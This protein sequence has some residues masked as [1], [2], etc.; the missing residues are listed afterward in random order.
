MERQIEELKAEVRR[1]LVVDDAATDKPS[2]KLNM[3]NGIQ[4]LGVA[5]HFETEVA[6]ALEHIFLT[7]DHIYNENNDDDALYN[8]A[9]RFKLLRQ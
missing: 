1:K 8:V 4:R 5:Y 7:Y 2:Q 3:I 6:D 9:L